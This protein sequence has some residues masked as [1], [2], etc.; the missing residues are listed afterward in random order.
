VSD[1]RTRGIERKVLS[2]RLPLEAY[3]TFTKTLHTEHLVIVE[4]SSKPPQGFLAAERTLAPPPFGVVD[5]SLKSLFL[6]EHRVVGAALALMYGAF[7]SPL[8]LLPLGTC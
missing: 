4:M 7:D 8:S 3:R 6:V 1:V 5:K 2:T